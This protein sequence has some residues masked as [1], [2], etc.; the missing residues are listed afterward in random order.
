MNLL[1]DTTRIVCIGIGATLVMDA[2]LF[3]LKRLGVPTLDFALVGRWVGHLARG[4]WSHEAIRAS[5]PVRGELALG[6]LAHYGVGIAFAALLAALCG[7]AWTRHPTPLPALLVGAGT[8][9]VP[10]LVMQPAMGAGIASS[11]TATP[12]RNCLRSLA[13]H[14]VFGAGLYLAALA[15]R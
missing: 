3:L 7:V 11:R 14:T 6:W 10:L 9:L 4:R 12:L 15:I 5:P 2:W 1:P 8:V 13:N